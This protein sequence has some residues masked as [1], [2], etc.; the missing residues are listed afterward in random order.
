[1]LPCRAL[2]ALFGFG[3]DDTER[4]GVEVR[5]HAVH[6]ESNQSD[7][8]ATPVE[9]PISV[10]LRLPFAVLCA[11]HIFEQMWGGEGCKQD[12]VTELMPEINSLMLVQVKAVVGI[13]MMQEQFFKTD[14]FGKLVHTTGMCR[15]RRIGLEK[16]RG[17]PPKE[18]APNSFSKTK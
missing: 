7:F 14:G 17:P 6:A 16:H 1:M 11:R 9:G 18:W 10:T 15:G 5:A 13:V 4:N 8:L 12:A 3:I 2:D